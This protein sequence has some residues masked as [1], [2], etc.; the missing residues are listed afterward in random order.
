MN[1]KDQVLAALFECAFF[2]WM[3]NADY[4][5]LTP[6]EAWAKWVENELDFDTVAGTVQRVRSGSDGSTESTTAEFIENVRGR[7]CSIC[8]DNPCCCVML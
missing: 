7:V 4:L 3:G 6:P 1:K 2:D 5:T 8:Q